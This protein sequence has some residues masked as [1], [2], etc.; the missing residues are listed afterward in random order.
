MHETVL[1]SSILAILK[2]SVAEYQTRKALPPLG[3]GPREGDGENL[4]V[5]EVVLKVGV[6]ACVEPQTLR[7]CFEIMAEGTV[8]EKSLLTIERQPMQGRCPDCGQEVETLERR[9]ACPLC[10]SEHVDWQGGQGMEIVSIRVEPIRC[11]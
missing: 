7:G 1:A 8:A 6:L 11:V 3:D 2:D 4:R 10:Q 9:F 5:A